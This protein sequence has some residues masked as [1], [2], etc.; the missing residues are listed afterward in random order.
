VRGQACGRRCGVISARSKQR[1]F[2]LTDRQ[3][4]RPTFDLV[5][6]MCASKA[7]QASRSGTPVMGSAQILA[8]ERRLDPP[9]AVPGWPLRPGAGS[10]VDRSRACITTRQALQAGVEGVQSDHVSHTAYR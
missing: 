1:R 2:V 5:H 9:W 3:L 10:Y 6:D 4:L 7:T 8:S